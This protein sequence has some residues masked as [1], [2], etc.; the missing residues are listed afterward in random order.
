MFNFLKKRK[1]LSTAGGGSHGSPISPIVIN[2]YMEAFE[3]KAL[4]TSPYPLVCGT[5]M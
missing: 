5:D 2:L 1:K 4:S 3:T